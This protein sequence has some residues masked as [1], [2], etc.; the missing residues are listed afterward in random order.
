MLANFSRT[1][2][3]LSI[4]AAASSQARAQLPAAT[5]PVQ[6]MVVLR[7]GEVIEGKITLYEGIYIVD[8]PNGRIRIKQAE[9]DLACS[10]LEEGYRRK[11]ATIQVGSV[12]D[13][14]DLAQWCMRHNLLGLASVE[15]ADATAADPKNPM[16]AALR[17]RLKMAME[18]PMPEHRGGKKPLA[19]GPSTDELDRMVRGMPRG[20]VEAFTQSVQPL[21]LNNCAT[22]GCHGPQSETG[23]RFWHIASGRPSSRRTTQRNLYSALQFIDRE[24]PSASKLLTAAVKPHGTAKQAIL[25]EH[26]SQQYR[27]M[28]DWAS[29]MSRAET[30][31]QPE[32][33]AR[34]GP[35]EVAEP[36]FEADAPERLSADTGKAR[37]LTAANR[38]RT[39]R[40]TGGTVKK[41]HALP[42]SFD[43]RNDPFDPEGFNRRYSPKKPGGADRVSQ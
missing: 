19:P 3:F 14:L 7:N 26:Q 15:L 34:R 28:L 23:L 9:V 10:N 6:G 40:D 16:I 41:G 32:T 11:R 36:P 39:P 1:A 21:L 4:L 30:M 38:R 20:V 13:H 8:L 31:E 42:A 2:V 25:G 12:H 5:A 35:P 22:A 37:P 18:P 33:V 24:N 43:Q 29:M 17:H 27:R